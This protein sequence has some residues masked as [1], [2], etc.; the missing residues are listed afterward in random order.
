M[1]RVRGALQWPLLDHNTRLNQI[2]DPKEYLGP[3]DNVEILDHEL[4][5][6]N[7][8]QDQ[9]IC[10]P[11]YHVLSRTSTPIGTLP[12]PQLDDSLSGI[13]QNPV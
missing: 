1:D 3:L 7:P 4:R 6:E 9:I 12:N 11:E 2:S 13:S 5:A 10:S 8:N